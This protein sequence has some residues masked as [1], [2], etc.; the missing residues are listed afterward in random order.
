FH[1]GDPAVDARMQNELL[2]GLYR[3]GIAM[4]VVPYISYSLSEDDVDYTIA[5]INEVCGELS[6]GANAK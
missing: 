2:A 3:R 5:C 1:S 6:V 4:Y